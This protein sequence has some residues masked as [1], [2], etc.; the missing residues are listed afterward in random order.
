MNCEQMFLDS[1]ISHDSFIAAWAKVPSLVLA[2]ATEKGISSSQLMILAVLAAALIL[3]FVAGGWIA[4]MLKMPTYRTRIGFIIFAVASAVLVLLFGQLKQGVD[5][6]GGTI[7]VY[8]LDPKKTLLRDGDE[9]ATPV[10][11]A[12]V[13][14]SLIKRINPSGT[15]EILIRPYGESQVEI[16]VPAVQENEVEDV[17]R[18]IT[19]AGILTFS[20]V[21]T[22]RASDH[23]SLIETATTNSQNPNRF[24]AL[25]RDIYGPGGRK[26]GFWADVD[27]EANA[28][29]DGVVPLRIEADDALLRNPDDGSLLVL[30]AEVRG[31]DNPQLALAKYLQ[32]EGIQDVQMLMVF[33]DL[34]QITGEDL[35]YVA[36]SYDNVGMPS[37]RFSLKDEASSRFYTLTSNN[38]PE[39][40]FRR[41]L[42]IVLDDLLLAAPAI[43]DAISGEGTISGNFTS[44][45]VARYVSI[46]RAGQLPAAL[47]KVPTSENRIGS[48]L[49]ADTI[50]KGTYAT[51]VS[52][53]A[54]L[55]FMLLYYRFLG[56][57]SCIALVMN[58]LLT[59]AVMILINQPITLPGLAGLVLTVGMSVDA[60]VLIFERI[61]EELRRGAAPRMAVRN[62]FA[63]ATTT[64][65]DANLTTLITAI[66]L[67]AI[68]TDQIRGFAVTLVLGIL[69][70]MFTAIYVSRTIIDIAERHRFLSLGMSD[71]VNRLRG[72]Y[73]GK[74]DIDFMG[75]GRAAMIVSVLGMIIG[76]FALVFRGRDILDIDFAGGSSVTFQLSKP[77]EAD[78]VRN[79]VGANLKDPQGQDLPF[80]LNRVDVTDSAANTVYKVDAAFDDNEQLKTRLRE[81]FESTGDVSLVTYQVDITPETPTNETN[82]T[83]Q[84]SPAAPAPQSSG[85]LEQWRPGAQ[86][87]DAIRLVAYQEPQTSPAT[88]PPPAD[89]PGGTD[90]SVDSVAPQDVPA[91]EPA[92]EKPAVIA[93]DTFQPPAPAATAVDA[94]G[95]A[96]AGGQT[97]SVIDETATIQSDDGVAATPGA[98]TS[99][100]IISTA[101]VQFSVRGTGEVARISHRGLLDAIAKAGIA[102]GATLEQRSIDA[103]PMGEKASE[104]APGS[105]VPFDRWK[106][107]LNLPAQQADQV[108]AILDQQISADPVWLSSSEIKSSVARQMINRALAAMF[109]SLVFIVGYI[110]FRFERIAFGL[111][112]VAALIHDVTLTLGA[113]ALSAWLSGVLGFLLVD[114]FKISLTVI[115]ALLTIVGYSLNDTI[116][117]FDRIRETRGK[118]PRLTSQMINQSVN[119]TLSRTLLTSLTTLLVVVLLYFFGGPGIHAFAF[120]LV[121]GIT[122]G[123]YSSIFVA[124]PILLWLVNRDQN[125]PSVQGGAKT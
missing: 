95:V 79:L 66:V 52:L 41:R 51:G 102:A 59:V 49:G 68:G 103:V 120:A 70:S 125:L 3:P 116:V 6:N 27:R 81:A 123:T 78:Q 40:S 44:E 124:S 101:E 107:S 65:I 23:R 31:S 45:E 61:R 93:P 4:K 34:L 10:T 42:G 25:Q 92:E 20:I 86:A 96:D 122:V 91:E 109:A 48:T 72:A 87:E 46:L 1:M 88:E 38:K 13:V 76:V 37:V 33:D 67:Y 29:V 56:I 117:V 26:I 50:R 74:A 62:G 98:T 36:Q 21:A 121:V 90:A 83:P 100:E 17:K 28:A 12:D 69:F 39:G 111:A 32:G 5:I 8:E 77:M 97:A 112:A 64:I 14:P 47:N 9:S 57:V 63:R 99:E 58:L 113:I 114:P 73:S 35:S 53:V 82:Q 55:V 54:V 2:Q 75:I 106:V 85:Q 94:A 104:W 84:E 22:P 110:W 118:S 115:A 119:N 89:A 80:T 11:A 16:I 15:E 60:N 24:V 108:F 18:L 19:E 43:N 7:L 105:N 30:P 71:L